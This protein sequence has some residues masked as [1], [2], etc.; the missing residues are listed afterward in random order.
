MTNPT[1]KS[2]N[3]RSTLGR[4][5]GLGASGSGVHHWWMQRITAVALIPLTIWFVM[6]LLS[7]V[8]FPT[9]EMVATWLTSPF[10]AIA[11]S[12]LVVAM[13]T[14]AS[15]GLGEVIEDYVKC[16]LKKYGSLIFIKF[17]SFVLAAACILS[18]MRLHF[19]DTG[20]NL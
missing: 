3:F 20:F 6:S 8:M 17:I 15:I 4:A 13:F 19:I 2:N 14:H 7:A 5:K 10:N 12:L 9:P 11:L 1:N 18:I 16:P